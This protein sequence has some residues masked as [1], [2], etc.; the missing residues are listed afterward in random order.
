M[1]DVLP[2]SAGVTINNLFYRYTIQKDPNSD[3][4]VTVRNANPID[5]GYIFSETDDWSGREGAT[6]QK[7]FPLN[8]IDKQFWGNGEILLEGEGTIFNPD[9]RYGYKLDPCYEPLSSPECPG[10]DAALY[11]W[12]KLNGLLDGAEPIDPYN[13]KEVQDALDNEVEIDEDDKY[14]EETIQTEDEEKRRKL[15]GDNS[16]LMAEAAAKQALFDA[17]ANMPQFNDYLTMNIDG[18]EYIETVELKDGTLPDN[19]RA[20]GRLANDGKFNEIVRSQYDR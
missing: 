6:I 12:L 19:R 4:T 17:M 1:T 7:F 8:D 14:K 20:F 18:K 11:D 5:G 3:A 9:V 15:A 16:A 2:P 10:F 13:S